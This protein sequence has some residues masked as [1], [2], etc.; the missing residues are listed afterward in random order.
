MRLLATRNNCRHVRCG[1]SFDMYCMLDWAHRGST[2]H[3]TCAPQT[4]P[5]PPCSSMEKDAK[6][7]LSKNIRRGLRQRYL[8]GIK[9]TKILMRKLK[10]KKTTKPFHNLSQRAPSHYHFHNQSHTR[11][12]SA[13]QTNHAPTCH[14]PLES[15]LHPKRRVPA[16]ANGLGRPPCSP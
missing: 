14:H 1:W 3:V 15:A 4:L 10:V 12:P 8:L 2:R 13:G 6:D 11:N 7:V 16:R 9:I 5:S